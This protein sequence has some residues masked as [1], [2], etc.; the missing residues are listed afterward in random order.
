MSREMRSPYER[1]LGSRVDELHPV[2]RSYFA[3]IPAGSVGIGEGVFERFGTQH[4]WLW[5]FLAVAERCRVIVPGMHH[6]V[7]F[8]IENRTEDG[9]Q[10][11]TRSLWL[12]SGEWSMVDAV[13]FVPD[14]ESSS[15]E[16]ASAG[17]DYGFGGVVDVLGRPAI[18]EAGFSVD[19]VDGG[20]AADQ[21]PRRP[22]ALGAEDSRSR[23]SFG[24]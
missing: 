18:V 10:T 2:L 24:W 12:G 13:S 15:G 23:G 20:T 1:A 19:V 7:P 3:V 17:G 21:S 16:E 14:R 9:R 4:R 8:R 6:D 22:A 5:P 11:A